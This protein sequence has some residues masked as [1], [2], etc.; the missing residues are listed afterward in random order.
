MLA[1]AL[2]STS[3]IV[4][5]L[6]N[7][8]CAG[9]LKYPTDTNIINEAQP[10]THS[11]L[12]PLD[13]EAFWDELGDLVSDEDALRLQSPTHRPHSIVAKTEVDTWLT[14]LDSGFRPGGS[15]DVV[16]FE[17][18]SK[19]KVRKA[20]EALEDA[21]YITQSSK[22]LKGLDDLLKSG[23]QGMSEDEKS[24]GELKK[25]KNKNNLD[26]IHKL[27]SK[28]NVESR[29]E[30]MIYLLIIYK[31]EGQKNA[32]H[33]L[34]PLN[35]FLSELKPKIARKSMKGTSSFKE[36]VAQRLSLIIKSSLL[37]IRIYAELYQYCVE[38]ENVRALQEEAFRYL[39]YFWRLALT[40]TEDEKSPYFIV[41]KDISVEKL[42]AKAENALYFSGTPEIKV[43]LAAW[44]GTHAFVFFKWNTHFGRKHKQ[45]IEKKAKFYATHYCIN[46]SLLRRMPTQIIE[47]SDQERISQMDI[48]TPAQVGPFC[49]VIPSLVTRHSTS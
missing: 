19:I 22:K 40:K 37:Q 39:Q 18:K 9:L 47:E 49:L 3:L 34:A 12:H 48:S 43:A 28:E 38:E 44:A 25:F 8:V 7:G 14:A 6:A 10:S 5:S 1:L 20:A 35:V 41:H 11:S 23:Q 45:E 30:R 36:P 13:D 31:L 24:W 29:K 42:L 2:L 46:T 26:I 21:N 32:S 27:P 16:R 4:I 17:N 15:S 33:F